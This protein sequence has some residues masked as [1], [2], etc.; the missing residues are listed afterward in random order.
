MYLFEKYM[1]I[2]YNKHVN[3]HYPIYLITMTDV[4][5]VVTMTDVAV[6]EKKHHPIYLIT[7]TDVAVAIYLIEI[8]HNTF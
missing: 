3:K 2:L 6:A 7:M 4:A 8:S 1:F 5:V